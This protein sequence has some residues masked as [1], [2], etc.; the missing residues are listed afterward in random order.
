[1]L[2]A[3]LFGRTACALGILTLPILS[4]CAKQ[5]TVTNS[6]SYQ[7]TYASS[8]AVSARDYGFVRPARSADEM[9]TAAS[10]RRIVQPNN[11]L[12]SGGDLWNRVRAGMRL[13]LH[14]NTRIDTKF[15]Q[16]RRDPRY[17]E[18][19]SAKASP[20]LP[21]I[22]NEIEQRGL[23]MELALLPHIESRYNPAATSPKA[24]G[25]MWQFMP[26]T[27]REMG[28]RLDQNY[29]ERRDV[30]AST[31]AALDYLTQIN[32]R[33]N[34]DWA[35][36]MAAYNCGPARVAAAMDA[37]RRAGKPTDFWALDL[38]TET[39]QYVPQ[40]LAAAR[41]VTDARNYGLRLPAIADQPR[42]EMLV[43]REPMN[44]VKVATASGVE[45]AEI[46]RLNPEIKSRWLGN[47]DITQLTVP[48]GT[49]AKLSAASAKVVQV[50]PLPAVLDR[51]SAS[52]SQRPSTL[53]S[54]GSD[55]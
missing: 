1:M 37:N 43:S 20:Y 30:L 50:K 3:T 2:D 14:A 44:L 24:A 40:I 49:G 18:K 32:R 13:D 29:D 41:L 6:T 48:A 51:A 21:T 33:F 38:P 9:G 35:L 23:P 27:A 11:M 36:T 31:R 52:R 17:L 46:Q 47:K 45:F 42:R 7:D 55:S 28:L 4:G 53:A 39:E 15:D 5:P 12:A 10:R 25:G 54:F 19:M 34:G 8:G 26:Y 16:F 22:V